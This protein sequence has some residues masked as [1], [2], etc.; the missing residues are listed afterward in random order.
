MKGGY[1]ILD[2]SAVKF[3]T[4]TGMTQTVP[5]AWEQV[6]G[7]NNKLLIV[8]GLTHDGELLADMVG[9]Y[10]LETDA[11]T[12]STDAGYGIAITDE[13]GVTLTAPAG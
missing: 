9:W 12:I 6:S 2:L 11:A 8:S 7:A 4:S 3:V 1:Q 5:G 13:D 10:Q